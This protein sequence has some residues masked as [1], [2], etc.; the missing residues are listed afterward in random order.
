MDPSTF[1]EF[2]LHPLGFIQHWL[3]AGPCSTPYA[4][5]IKDD[6]TYR[7]DA[8]DPSRVE[9]P[10]PAQLHAQGPFGQSWRFHNPGRNYFVEYSDFWPAPTLVDLYAYTEIESNRDGDTAA[11]FWA[12]GIADLWVNDGHF[13]QFRV[14]GYMHPEFQPITLP[15]RRGRNRLCMRL[16]V[17]AIRDTRFLFGL[18]FLESLPLTVCVPGTAALVGPLRW[19]DGVK[20]SGIDG[21]TSELP[22]PSSAKVIYS[23]DRSLPWPVGEKHIS[24]SG[25]RPF[26]FEVKVECEDQKLALSFEVPANRIGLPAGRPNDLRHAHLDYIASAPDV[27]FV[28]GVHYSQMPLLARRL[29]RRTSSQDAPAFATMIQYINGRRDCSDF[30]LATLLR[31]VRLGLAT[32]EESAEIRRTALDFR[33]WTDEPGCDAMCFGTENHSLLFHGCQFMAGKMYP[34]EVFTNSGR[35][36]RDHVQHGLQRTRRWLESAEANGFSEFLSSTY[37]PI[38]MGALLNVVDFSPEIEL[39]NRASALVDR[40]Y[41]DLAD[42]AFQGLTVGP[43]GRVYRNVLYP[44]EGGTQA[45]LSW[46]VPEA[47]PDFSPRNG[48]SKERTGDW[49]AFLATSKNYRP[50]DGLAERMNQAASRRYSQAGVEIV[51]HKTSDYILTSLAVPRSDAKSGPRPGGGGYQEHLWQATLG[52]GCHVFV[53][54]PGCSYDVDK[55]SRPGYWYGNGVLPVVR[56]R[57]G[58]L[59]TIFNIP[60]GTKS[61]GLHPI[62]FTHAYWPADAFEQQKVH[63]HWVFGR[64]GTGFI[65][66]W[67]SERLESQDD[68][69]TGRELRAPGYRSAWVAITGGL[70]EHKSF[71]AFMESCSARTPEFDRDKLVLQ[72]KGE[73]PLGWP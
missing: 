35:T 17:A 6:D 72:M 23:D 58:I 25:V 63:G 10:P 51:L 43:Q 54:H 22:A 44:E 7:R 64:K 36:G 32:P 61:S 46:A 24:F 68:I 60:D 16:Q 52:G 57:E 1:G 9:P 38:T 62:P 66:L 71:E 19:L 27:D 4:G 49:M 50:P 40:L 26:R 18:Q 69:L 47:L 11:R 59:Q 48:K 55:L 12:A 2:P 20:A 8:V 3:V 70:S 31:L 39:S 5:T 15:L 45:L 30:A 34:G 21:A 41:E 67:C 29:L 37:V 56:Q 42:H 14:P 53:N 33:Y 13:M 28:P 65:G 73:E